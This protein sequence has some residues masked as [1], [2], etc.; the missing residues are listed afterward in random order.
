[1]KAQS[2]SRFDKILMKFSPIV[3]R[4]FQKQL[5]YLIS[6]I[7][8][9]SLHAKKYDEIEGV[10][11]ARVDDS[12]RFYFVIQSDTYVLLDIQKHSD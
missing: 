11:Q 5:S 3:R 4:R 9:P 7:R 12:I 8:H 1:M 10:W 2:S 6:D